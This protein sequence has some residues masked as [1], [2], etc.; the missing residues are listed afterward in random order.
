LQ[1]EI[2]VFDALGKQINNVTITYTSDNSGIIDTKLMA[3]GI[4][5]LM[6]KTSKGTT[7][8]KLIKAE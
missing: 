1:P 6:L 4:Y 8:K 7:A 3:S 5:T 2:I